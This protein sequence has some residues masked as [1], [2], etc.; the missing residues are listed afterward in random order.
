MFVD[1]NGGIK[2]QF[3]GKCCRDAK[4]GLKK[5]KKPVIIELKSSFSVLKHCNNKKISQLKRRTKMKKSLIVA[6]VI[7]AGLLYISGCENQ[8]QTDA[9]VGALAGAGIGAIVGHQSGKAT[10]GALIGGAVGGGTGYMVGNEQDKKQAA[11]ENA[12]IRQEMNNITVNVT[13][14]NGSIIQVVLRKQGV[15]YVG[16]RGEYYP[17]FPTESQLRP[18]YGF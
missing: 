7:I 16:P 15:G 6:S 18:V 5:L 1:I 3:A 9:G 12:N 8:S 11:A 14:S 17:S 10:Q 2:G 13:N 4:G